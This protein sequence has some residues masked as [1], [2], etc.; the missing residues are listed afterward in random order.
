MLERAVLRSGAFPFL[1]SFPYLLVNMNEL[2]N[3]RMIL[4]TISKDIYKFLL[5][6][7]LI[8]SVAV[9]LQAL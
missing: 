6:F 5:C 1:F 9:I 7:L 4:D 2:M 8:L 3:Y